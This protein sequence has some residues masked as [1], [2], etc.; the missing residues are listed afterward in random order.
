MAKNGCFVDYGYD[1]L[2]IVVYEFKQ[3]LFKNAPIFFRRTDDHHFKQKAVTTAA[4]SKVDFEKL[5]IITKRE[6]KM[7][8][9]PWSVMNPHYDIVYRT[10]RRY[11]KSSSIRW[12]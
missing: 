2:T 10:H 6:Q 1:S 8:A 4:I 3:K 9:C 12:D 7:I 11:R 5:Y